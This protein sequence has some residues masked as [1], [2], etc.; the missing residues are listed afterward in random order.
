MN[1]SK[2]AIKMQALEAAEAENLRIAS[3]L[4]GHA[5]ISSY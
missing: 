3:Y 5:G 4:A 2:T 1:K